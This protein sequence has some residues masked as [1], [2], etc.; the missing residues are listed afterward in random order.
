ML[1]TVVLSSSASLSI[2]IPSY[3]TRM[4]PGA[5]GGRELVKIIGPEEAKHVTVSRDRSR[6]FA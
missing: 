4:R 5:C 1:P 2:R 3:L 6:R